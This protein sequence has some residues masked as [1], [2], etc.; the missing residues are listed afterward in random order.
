VRIQA[1]E[2]LHNPDRR[3]Q[4]AGPVMGTARMG[5]DAKY[6]VVHADLR[7]FDH[8]NHFIEGGAVFPAGG[9]GNPTLTIAALALRSVDAIK[10]TLSA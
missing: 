6:A 2:I 7:T 8:P 5:R 3:S 4:G 10:P 1:T 9:A